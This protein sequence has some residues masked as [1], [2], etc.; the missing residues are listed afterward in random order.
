[1]SGQ[2]FLPETESYFPRKHLRKVNRNQKEKEHN[3]PDAVAH[4]CTL[5]YSGGRYQKDRGSKPVQADSSQDPISKKPTIKK[6]WWSGSG[7]RF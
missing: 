4:S 3:L 2:H 1:L 7:Y 6:G 5:K